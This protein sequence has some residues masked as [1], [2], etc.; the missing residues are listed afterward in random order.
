V[1]NKVPHPD[2]ARVVEWQRRNPERHYDNVK[3]SR[4]GNPAKARATALRNQARQLAAW[5]LAKEHQAAW[6]AYYV[7][8]CASRGVDPWPRMG[9]P[10]S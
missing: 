2:S 8:E 7:Q 3:R 1:N 10:S 5:R 4:A 9:R 6:D